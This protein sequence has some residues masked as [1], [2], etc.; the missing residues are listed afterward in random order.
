MAQRQ[1]TGHSGKLLN[2]VAL[3]TGASGGMGS[4]I[5]RRLAQA[6]ARVCVHYHRSQCDADALVSELTNTTR[7]TAF[8]A[9]LRD[10]I[11]VKVLIEHC[12]KHFGRLDILVNNAGWSQ[13]VPAENL[14]ELSDDV[15]NQT[16]ALKI[17]GPLYCVRAAR[18]Y[19]AISGQGNIVNITS[20]AGIAA[21]GST[22]IYAAANAALSNLTRSWARSLAPEIRV[23]AVAPGFVNTGLV[24]PMDGPAAERIAK[25]NYLGRTITAAEIADA[26]YFICAEAPG[27]IGEEIVIDGGIGRLGLKH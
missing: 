18:P 15:I 21:K 12:I 5:C 27:M 17:H 6:G 9:D 10:E 7:A 8:A 25:N 14:D 1:E 24:Y 22:I 13:L 4:A 23:N 26:V 20:V 2:Q 19:L 16:L 11:Q 3:V